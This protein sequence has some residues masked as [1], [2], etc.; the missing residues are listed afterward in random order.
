MLLGFMALL[1]LVAAAACTP[2]QSAALEAA[3]QET[4]AQYRSASLIVRGE[5]TVAHTNALGEPCYDLKVT[6]VLAGDY[7]TGDVIHAATAMVPGSDYVLYLGAAVDAFHTEDQMGYH[8]L[9]EPLL[10]QGDEVII[11]GT[12]VPY[13]LLLEEL[14]QQAEI[15]A[16][17]AKRY[18]YEELSGLLEHSDLVFLGEVA[19]VSPARPHQVR[20]MDNGVRTQ[21]E[22]MLS[23]A[24]LRAYSSVQGALVYG[25]EVTLVV[26]QNGIGGLVDGATLT[27]RPEQE[28]EPMALERGMIGLFFL[29]RGPDIKQRYYFPINSVQGFVPLYGDTLVPLAHNTALRPYH[30]L[31][32]FIAQARALLHVQEEEPDSPALV[33]E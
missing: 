4:R 2:D 11:G 16:A 8:A 29:N 9:T 14:A 3:L 15:V 10:L 7:Q 31:S 20:T 27:P 30:D 12:G 6:Q 19:R 13:A 21:E 33:L 18:F 1:L 5:C 24:T 25:D 28:A 17:P 32:A 26:A 22:Q 23:F